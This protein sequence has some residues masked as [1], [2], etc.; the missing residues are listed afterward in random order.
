MMSDTYVFSSRQ[1][2]TMLIGKGFRKIV[3]LNLDTEL[4]YNMS[5][6]ALNELVKLGVLYTEDETFI[7]SEEVREIVTVLGEAEEF[8]II[9][10]KKENLSDICC[11][12][13]D[14]LML[15]RNVQGNNDWY[16][17][18]FVSLEEFYDILLDDGYLP[19][20]NIDD[21]FYD[22][23][24]EDFEKSVV[25]D[26][27]SIIDET[28]PVLFSLDVSVKTDSHRYIRIMDYYFFR[29]IVVSD[30]KEVKR[31]AYSRKKFNEVFLL[32]M[33]R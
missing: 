32:L 7:M 26:A 18:S 8:D 11:Y 9:H 27:L 5:T 14:K 33:E 10:T 2:K 29:Y 3:G 30:G 16:S 1:M 23:G 28:I 19:A 17:F 25:V 4:D 13:T 6:Q 24:L 20:D 22:D 31:Y 21:L 15:V 12:R